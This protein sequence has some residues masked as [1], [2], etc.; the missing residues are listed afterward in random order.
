[1]TEPRIYRPGDTIRLEV[2]VEDP[3]GV[4]L[5]QVQFAHSENREAY[6]RINE[7][8]DPPQNGTVVL[9][10]PVTENTVP[11]EYRCAFIYREDTVGNHSSDNT[12]EHL[13]F[14]VEDAS[15]DHEAPEL[16]GARLS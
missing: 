5:V 8:F 10:Y 9:E 6:I 4:K 3:S 11:G 13:R 7:N 16:K 14:R 2:D 15:G 12:P 1:M